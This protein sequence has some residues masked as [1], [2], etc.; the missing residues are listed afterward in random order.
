MV[1]IS[2]VE[3]QT[4]LYIVVY[5][6]IVLCRTDYNT[7][8]PLKE[9]PINNTAPPRSSH[10]THWVSSLHIYSIYYIC[11]VNNVDDSVQIIQP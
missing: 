4:M 11:Q 3:S 2:A 7:V 1:Y 5:G 6:Y 10:A 8:R 9:K